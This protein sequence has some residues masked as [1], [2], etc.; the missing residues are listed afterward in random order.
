MGNGWGIGTWEP[1]ASSFRLPIPHLLP[2]PHYPLPPYTRQRAEAYM[3]LKP[4]SQSGIPAALQ[5]A[6]P[7]EP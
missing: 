2:I 7:V 3:Q 5:K 6:E 4:I 1:G